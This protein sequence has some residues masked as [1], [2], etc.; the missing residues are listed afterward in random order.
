M[1]PLDAWMDGPRATRAGPSRPPQSGGA[2][3]S[4]VALLP[5]HV[6]LVALARPVRLAAA[7]LRVLAS[8]APGLVRT[9]ILHPA[10]L[11]GVVLTR[12]ALLLGHRAFLR[13]VAPSRSGG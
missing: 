12:G 10:F 4:L 7:L 5:L 6:L 1:R 8:G 13:L 3:L 2:A 9:R 11:L